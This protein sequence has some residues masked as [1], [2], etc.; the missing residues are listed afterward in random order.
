MKSNK[1]LKKAFGDKLEN[2]IDQLKF[3]SLEIFY[4][5][6][7]DYLGGLNKPSESF[8]TLAQ[9]HSG[10][11]FFP[12]N[13]KSINPDN[14][15][16]YL[17][18]RLEKSLKEIEE[19]NDPDLEK[20]LQKH[21]LTELFV[22]LKNEYDKINEILRNRK[23]ITYKPKFEGENGEKWESVNKKALLTSRVQ[24]AEAL[25]KMV[26]YAAKNIEKPHLRVSCRTKQGFFNTSE[27][28]L[29]WDER[30]H[31]WRNSLAAFLRAGGKITYVY[32]FDEEGTRGRP[33]DLLFHLLDGGLEFSIRYHEANKPEFYKDAPPQTLVEY[34][35]IEHH[36]GVLA[37]ATSKDAKNA[38][39]HDSVDRGVIL[40]AG[41]DDNPGQLDLITHLANRF[42]HG[43][44]VFYQYDA[45][46]A[47][48]HSFLWTAKKGLEFEQSC[49]GAD[50]FKRNLPDKTRPLEWLTDPKSE[51]RQWLN[52]LKNSVSSDIKFDLEEYLEYEVKRHMAF[53]ENIKSGKKYREIITLSV[54]KEIIKL[55]PPNLSK[56]FTLSQ[57]PKLRIDRLERWKKL[58]EDYK[59]N[60]EVR[61]LRNE[62]DFPIL[63][64][65]GG[66]RKT[67]ACSS[68]G[69]NL[70]IEIP[71]D[72]S[73]EY[74]K[75][76][77]IYNSS[78]ALAEIYQ[79]SFGQLWGGL[80]GNKRIDVLGEI[81]NAISELEKFL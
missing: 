23:R 2:F 5:D 54:F 19:K 69:R 3:K 15:F 32:R 40:E 60:Y 14:L 75:Y 33:T 59:N 26:D 65:F 1:A 46:Q 30:L 50:L 7:L 53:E 49:D 76:V 72:P 63:R 70:L 4:R 39:N 58:I 20:D 61:I 74:E 77:Y 68:D 66:F 12:K 55:E 28:L 9:I 57:P 44:K 17:E 79:T 24:L 10:S 18:I 35:M 71:I 51:F 47:K 41:N 64:K 56:R 81:R 78:S 67:F 80:E 73:S 62:E 36:A 22:E 16:N 8:E 31:R 52:E 42:E 21:T 13:K 38:E 48:T 43:S 37:F 34:A 27:S 6:Y 29:E 11:R 25:I 45:E